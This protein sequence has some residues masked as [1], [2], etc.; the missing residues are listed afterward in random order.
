MLD[1]LNKSFVKDNYLDDSKI[2]T[3]INEELDKYPIRYKLDF[4][5]LLPSDGKYRIPLPT[6]IL[7]G[8]SVGCS[9]WANSSRFLERNYICFCSVKE[10]WSRWNRYKSLEVFL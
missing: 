8:R 10:F 6:A 1:K 3:Q 2:F 4:I 5:K 7:K 9:T